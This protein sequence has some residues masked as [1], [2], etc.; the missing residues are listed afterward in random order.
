MVYIH[1]VGC[2]DI[3]ITL[4]SSFIFLFRGHRDNQTHLTGVSSI[5]KFK[6]RYTTNLL[7]TNDRKTLLNM[8]L[9]TAF[10]Q[11]FLLI[12]NHPYRIYHGLRRQIVEK[13]FGQKLC[14]F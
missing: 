6:I 8:R 14:V 7:N 2:Y 13:K 10:M 12:Y 11:R 1:L 4:S 9:Y 5:G 3:L